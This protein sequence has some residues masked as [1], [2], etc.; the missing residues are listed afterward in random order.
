MSYGL[1][2]SASGVSTALY[3]QNVLA[4]NL[5]NMDT[6]GFKPDVPSQRTRLAARQED[7]LSY[8]PSNDLLERLGGGVLMGP[9]RIEFSQ[10]SLRT[11]E[12]PLD[13][14][15]RGDGFF[16]VKDES[17]TSGDSLRLTRDGRFTRDNRQRLVMAS[18]GLPVLDSNGREI[19][20]PPQG[21]VT[22]DGQGNILS[23]NRA[24]ARL[25][26]VEVPGRE[27]LRKLGEGLFGAPAEVIDGRRPFTGQVVQGAVEDSAVNE[28]KT[29]L[30]LQAAAREVDTNIWLMQQHDRLMER[31]IAG[32][33][34]VA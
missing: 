29:L 11:T 14:A 18:S 21:T 3:R 9:T 17:D 16:L 31:A 30:D 32:I 15:I 19:F 27:Q 25:G 2:I 6:A 5:A 20:V 28:I 4:N 22:I 23:G 33:G 12:N 10:G 1:Q 13:V 8:L 7:G 24:I 34:R 26:V